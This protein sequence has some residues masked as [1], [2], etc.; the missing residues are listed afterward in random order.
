MS[1]L[2]QCLTILGITDD[3]SKID[4]K[5]LKNIFKNKVLESHPDRSGS[6]DDFDKVM[7]S[8]LHL[9][10][11][12]MRMQGGRSSLQNILTPNELY[13]M[14]GNELINSIFQESSNQRLALLPQWGKEFDNEEFNKKFEESHV[15]E[16]GHGYQD[17]LKQANSDS[18]NGVVQTETVIGQSEITPET[19]NSVFEKSAK[20]GKPEVIHNSIICVESMSINNSIGTD[21][22]QSEIQEYS[23]TFPSELQYSDLYT[24]YN[25]STVIDKLP[26]FNSRSDNIQ[27][28][29]EQLKT[30][31]EEQ[32]NIT[33]D[34]KDDLLNYEKQQFEKEKKHRDNLIKSYGENAFSIN[35]LCN[36]FSLNDKQINDMVIEIK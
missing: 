18:E 15:S 19:F 1:Y 2:K 11:T 33:H 31:R 27:E 25:D 30:L 4:L 17:W 16:L 8:Y 22:I 10:E 36:N 28:Y 3:F 20:I 6:D 24:A 12:Y 34:E 9:H 21:L 26:S 35:M 5:Y 32:I 23:A 13:N 14:R 7:T 29:M